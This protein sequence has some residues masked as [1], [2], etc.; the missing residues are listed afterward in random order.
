MGGADTGE[1]LS[2]GVAFDQRSEVI[3]KAMATAG[4]G[5]FQEQQQRPCNYC[6]DFLLV[7]YHLLNLEVLEGKGYILSIFALQGPA[8]IVDTYRMSD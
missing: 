6:S 5:A 8:S 1:G 7:S 4:K 2:D 3:E